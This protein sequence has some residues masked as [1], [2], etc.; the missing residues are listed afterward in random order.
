MSVNYY[1]RLL[2]YKIKY[3]ELT[4]DNVGY[5]KLSKEVIER[6]KE[7]INR[8]SE[9]LKETIEG[10]VKFNNFKIKKDGSICIRCQSY[11]DETFVGVG[12]FDLKLFK[13]LNKN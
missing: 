3:P 8:I 4:Y 10:F 5:D 9:I 6:N 13:E 11:W 1:K 7:G 2:F 12:Y